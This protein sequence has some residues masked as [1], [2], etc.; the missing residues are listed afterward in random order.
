MPH[1]SKIA[2]ITRTATRSVAIFTAA[3]MLAGQLAAVAHFHPL[4]CRDRLNA[5]A[6]LS[7]DSGS[8]ALCLL[9]FHT[10]AKPPATPSVA[11][12]TSTAPSPVAPV[13]AVFHRIDST[14]ALTRAPPLAA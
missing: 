2:L 12:P 10:S 3:L 1:R 7:A 8:C 13:T 5:V 9:A 4:P 11:A 14:S 6:Q